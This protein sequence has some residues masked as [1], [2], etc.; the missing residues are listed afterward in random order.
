MIDPK[1]LQELKPELDNK[2]KNAKLRNDNG[3]IKYTTLLTPFS[4]SMNTF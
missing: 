2:I 4:D 1:A 3:E